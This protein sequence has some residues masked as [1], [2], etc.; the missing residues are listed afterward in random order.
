M[1]CVGLRE[2]G[3]TTQEPGHRGG[4]CFDLRHRVR[5]SQ[6]TREEVRASQLLSIQWLLCHGQCG[7]RATRDRSEMGMCGRLHTWQGM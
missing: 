7:R 6:G 1:P 2:P 3:S 4:W 5:E